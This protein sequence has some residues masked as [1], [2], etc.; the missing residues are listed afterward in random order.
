MLSMEDVDVAW[1]KDEEDTSF[2]WSLF[3]LFFDANVK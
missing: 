3:V 2:N 1:P